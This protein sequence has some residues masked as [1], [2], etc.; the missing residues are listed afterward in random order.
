MRYR[1]LARKT[2]QIWTHCDKKWFC[3]FSS[4]LLCHAGLSCDNFELSIK[5]SEQSGINTKLKPHAKC[6]QPTVFHRAISRSLSATDLLVVLV[7]ACSRPWKPQNFVRRNCASVSGEEIGGGFR[8]ERRTEWVKEGETRHHDRMQGVRKVKRRTE[9]K[10][11]RLLQNEDDRE[12]DQL[13]MHKHLNLVLVTEGKCPKRLYMEIKKFPVMLSCTTL[14]PNIFHTNSRPF[15]LVWSCQ[16]CPDL[17]WQAI[18][19]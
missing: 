1:I 2:L 15:F 4:K 12:Q 5:R 14:F 19:P 11:H 7:C 16:D 17:S 18:E 6:R 13:F 3:T 9:R 8:D 10:Y